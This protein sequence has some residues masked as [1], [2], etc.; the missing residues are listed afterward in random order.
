M[1]KDP[2]DTCVDESN[3]ETANAPTCCLFFPVSCGAVILSF[4]AMIL[5]G[6]PMVVGIMLLKNPVYY[7]TVLPE[8]K[9]NQHMVKMYAGSMLGLG[10]M[11]FVFSL[12]ALVG[13]A[14]RKANML[15]PLLL[16]GVFTC[17][18]SFFVVLDSMNPTVTH[19]LYRH[20]HRRGNVFCFSLL[21]FLVKMYFTLTIYQ[22][23]QQLIR[24]RRP[25]VTPA[26]LS[27]D[28]RMGIS[29]PIVPP[30]KDFPPAYA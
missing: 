15:I 12:M 5:S 3:E 20:Y 25:Q 30:L 29:Y 7:A 1:A 14:K 6:F 13:I 2:D 8:L 11:L 21:L 27:V 4:I 24:H 10:T 19:G 9:Y 18:L 22:T 28:T 16:M 26:S 17:V 23:Y